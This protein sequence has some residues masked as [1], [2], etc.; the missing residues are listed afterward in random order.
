MGFSI[1]SLY[2]HFKSTP[3]EKKEPKKVEINEWLGLGA[4]TL[5]ALILVGAGGL[6]L[7]AAKHN[8]GSLQFLGTIPAPASYALL[9]GA[10]GAII[11]DLTAFAIKKCKKQE[12]ETAKTSTPTPE[13]PSLSVSARKN[14]LIVGS[15]FF[16]VEGEEKAYDMRKI[17][18]EKL[19]R[20][21]I[22]DQQLPTEIE[23]L[24]RLL[25]KPT[26]GYVP[27]EG[28]AEIMSIQSE[29]V[30]AHLRVIYQTHQSQFASFF[31]R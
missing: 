28:E 15:L 16:P 8:I 4:T 23:A 9:A 5:L 24:K 22:V 10:G 7:A 12:S 27:Q 20:A 14:K 6:A 19:A 18:F 11:I 29:L 31:D 13:T 3:T 2:N 30:R 1:A 17:N 25:D 26:V 21:D